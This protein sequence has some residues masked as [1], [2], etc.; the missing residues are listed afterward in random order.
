MLPGSSFAR[1]MGAMLANTA[2]PTILRAGSKVNVIPGVAEAEI[3]GRLL[4]GQTRESFLAEL[5]A[6]LGDD[7]EL[8]VLHYLPP[9]VTE[10]RE[11][12]LYDAIVGV[13]RTHAP[14]SP[15]VPY[16]LPGFTDAKAFTSIGA[17]WYGFAPVKMPRS[18]RFADL[19][20]G[21]DERIPVEGLEWGTMVLAD[22]VDSFLG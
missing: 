6:V 2:S 17:K 7:V 22:L 11:S 14:E 5:R 3:D 10:P 12:E 8:E 19:F 16:L 20:H 4:P 18:V 1:G 15:V 21:N 9:V 13:M